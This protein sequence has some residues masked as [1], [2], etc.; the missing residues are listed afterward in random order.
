MKTESDAFVIALIRE[1]FNSED[2][3]TSCLRNAQAHGAEL[4]LLPELPLNTW[5]PATKLR[6][7][8][9][10]EFPGG[11]RETMLRSSARKAGIAVLGGVIRQRDDG[12]RV[13][14]ALLINAQG[15]MIGTSSKHVLPNE[16]GFWECDHYE[17]SL[18]PPK[19]IEYM[20]AKF[21]VQICSDA[22][23]STAAQLLAAQGVQVI[24]APRAT[25]AA[26]WNRWRLAYQAMAL[27][28][29]AWVISVNRPRS[30]FGVEIGGPSL[31]VNPMGEIVLE[32]EKKIAIHSVSLGEVIH[33]RQAYPGYLPWPAE[34][35]IAGWQEIQQNQS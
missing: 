6:K 25:S 29:A 32:S 19:V 27:T 30:E 21:G 8:E 13:N 17:A 23:R 34:M 31:I 11:W 10:A 15:N 7:S 9:D 20:G 16:E 12:S 1:I 4:A 3:L 33:A 14:L 18:D 24:L 22:N 28:S 5:S 26:S 2:T 35:Y